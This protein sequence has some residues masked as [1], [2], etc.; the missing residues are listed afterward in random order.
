MCGGAEAAVARSC[1]LVPSSV[2]GVVVR[3][4]AA[5]VQ[6][7]HRSKCGKRRLRSAK[8]GFASIVVRAGGV[9]VFRFLGRRLAR[10]SAQ[11]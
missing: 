11:S 9:V 10:P 4:A 7:L 6:A 2:H 5:L 3:R 8:V 1:I